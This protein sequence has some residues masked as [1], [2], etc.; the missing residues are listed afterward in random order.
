MLEVSRDT[1]RDKL[2][3][4]FSYYDNIK[5]EIEQNYELNY[6]KLKPFGENGKQFNLSI[7]STLVNSIRETARY[8]SYFICALML[9]LIVVDHDTIE[10][11]SYFT[12]YNY[13]DK[14]I[15]RIIC[16]V[17]LTLTILFFVL[18][19]IMKSKLSLSKYRRDAEEP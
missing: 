9:Y 4:L 15:M 14:L 19:L 13:Q 17:Q 8:V 5:E 16:G 18:W 11:T 12:Y 1:Q 3:S 6:L 2:I 7:T 10:Q